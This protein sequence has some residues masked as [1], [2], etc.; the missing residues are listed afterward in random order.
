LDETFAIRLGHEGIERRREKY[1][2]R[3]KREKEKDQLGRVISKRAAVPLVAQDPGSA[4]FFFPRF[5][6]PCSRSLFFYLS[7]TPSSILF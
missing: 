2:K 1:R 4:R 7:F 6:P 5:F 3:N